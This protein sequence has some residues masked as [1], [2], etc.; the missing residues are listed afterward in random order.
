MTVVLNYDIPKEKS[1]YISQ[2]SLVFLLSHDLT[3]HLVHQPSTQHLHRSG[4]ALLVH[5]A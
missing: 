1:M 3:C 2:A 5:E 4:V